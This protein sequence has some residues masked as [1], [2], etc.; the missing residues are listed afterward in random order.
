LNSLAYVLTNISSDQQ[1]IVPEVSATLGFA[2]EMRVA[3]NGNHSTIVKYSSEE[4][5][6]FQVVSKTIAGLIQHAPVRNEL[7]GNYPIYAC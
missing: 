3:L 5:H 6:N 1:I 2:G 7:Q 4:D